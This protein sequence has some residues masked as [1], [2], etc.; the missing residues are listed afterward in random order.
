MAYAHSSK[1]KI[2]PNSAAAYIMHIPNYGEIAII[3][4]VHYIHIFLP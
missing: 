1:S 3:R 4:N 2:I